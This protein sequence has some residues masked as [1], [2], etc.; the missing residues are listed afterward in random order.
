VRAFVFSRRISLAAPAPRPAVALFLVFASS[1]AL[2]IV[3][4]STRVSAKQDSP[5]PQ[6]NDDTGK[7]LKLAQEMDRKEHSL[8]AYLEKL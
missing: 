4:Q 5:S 1:L 7:V 2:W 8:Y 3:S 6:A